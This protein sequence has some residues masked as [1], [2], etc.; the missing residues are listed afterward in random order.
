MMWA[1][2][3][4]GRR[5]GRGRADPPSSTAIAPRHRFARPG[6][7]RVGRRRRHPPRA[8]WRHPLL[9]LAGVWPTTMPSDGYASLDERRGA[10]V[11]CGGAAAAGRQVGGCW[12]VGASHAA[13]VACGRLVVS[14]ASCAWRSR[15][16]RGVPRRRRWPP[17]PP[18]VANSWWP[19]SLRAPTLVVHGA[20]LGGVRSTNVAGEGNAA[21]RLPGG[22]CAGIDRDTQ[23]R[24]GPASGPASSLF[25]VDPSARWARWCARRW[26]RAVAA[27]PA[28]SRTATAEAAAGSPPRPHA[29][30]PAVSSRPVACRSGRDRF[31]QRGSA[32]HYQNRVAR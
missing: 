8:C 15:R 9:P 11:R 27:G 3:G 19:S 20:E 22:G 28:A 7:P 32:A 31:R 26:R 16:P 1:R 29:G 14:L 10:G 18:T 25:D 30:A 12:R 6:Q 21:R 24:R 5:R 2:V 23:G 4:V 17:P 13:A